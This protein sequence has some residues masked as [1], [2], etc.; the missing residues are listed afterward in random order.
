MK[1]TRETI[2]YSHPSERWNVSSLLTFDGEDRDEEARRKHNQQL[3]K[4]ALLQQMAE[5]KRQKEL[6]REHEM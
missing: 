4:Q 6:N 3:Q 5:N 2:N 1:R